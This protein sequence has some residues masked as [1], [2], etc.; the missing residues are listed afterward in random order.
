[1]NSDGVALSV[2]AK[3]GGYILSAGT[4][5][6]KWI[7]GKLFLLEEDVNIVTMDSTGQHGQGEEAVEQGP[8][9]QKG[10]ECCTRR[11]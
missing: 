10:L 2:T 9:R 8:A 11:A 1:M 7:I 3:S 5:R 4:D 6:E